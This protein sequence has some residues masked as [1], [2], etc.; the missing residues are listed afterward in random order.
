MRQVYPAYD[1]SIDAASVDKGM[2]VY[3]RDGKALGVVQEVWATIEPHGEVAKSR[4]AQADYGPIRGT[5]HLFEG[6]DGYVEV[7]QQRAIGRQNE[8]TLYVPLV[9][10]GEISANRDLILEVS[11]EACCAYRTRRPA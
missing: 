7:R 5:M 4:F 3:D 8:P 1:S 10:V 2:K 9:A 11:G 6:A